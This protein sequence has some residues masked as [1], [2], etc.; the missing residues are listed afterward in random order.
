VRD[1]GAEAAVDLGS[2]VDLERYPVDDVGAPARTA[3]QSAARDRLHAE[4]VAV[5]PEFLRADA[6]PALVAECEA[7]APSGHHSVA[8][9]TPYL[10]APDPDVDSD[11]P[12]ARVGRS[13]LGAVAY[14]LFPAG[15]ALRSLYESDD[16]MSFVADLLGEEVL[17]RYAD[18][19]GA[20]N[21]AVMGEGDVLDWH[22]DQTDFVVSIALQQSESGGDFEVVA[23]VR[24]EVDER[25]DAVADVLDGRTSPTILPMDPGTL[26]LFKGRHSIHRVSPV[27]G[28]RPRYVALLA[29]DTKPGTDS[30]ERLKL[31]RYGRLP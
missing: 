21:L 23:N 15:S 29:Y 10:A 28:D 31:S 27:Q 18:P 17:Y 1:I 8:R 16:L 3:V 25:Y 11:H 5:L 9:G 4:G 12:R 30:T 2:L 26:M 7:L 20:L 6:L 19:F 22:F 14:D 13:S 24:D